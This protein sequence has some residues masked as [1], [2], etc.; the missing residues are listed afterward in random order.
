M[1]L[2][3][4]AKRITKEKKYT[5][6]RKLWENCGEIDKEKRTSALAAGAKGKATLLQSDNTTEKKRE[7][8]Q[9]QR[10]KKLERG[11]GRKRRTIITKLLLR[12]VRGG[13]STSLKIGERIRGKETRRL[14]LLHSC[15]PW[16]DRKGVQYEKYGADFLRERSREPE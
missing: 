13:H 2:Q 3:N 4:I 5:E 9:G 14:N 12:W 8:W 16:C 6:R 15:N 7:R 11:G 1:T 10:A